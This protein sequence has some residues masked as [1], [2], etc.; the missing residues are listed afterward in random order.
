MKIDIPKKIYSKFLNKNKA[1]YN[2]IQPLQDKSF[3]AKIFGI[4]LNKTGTTTLGRVLK[5]MGKK[6]CSCRLDIL[7]EC[8]KG[9]T[10][11]N[12]KRCADTADM[13]IF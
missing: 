10:W 2:S 8:R 1:L 4:G 13:S 5:D 7:N 6:H 3:S 12:E 9:K 11:K